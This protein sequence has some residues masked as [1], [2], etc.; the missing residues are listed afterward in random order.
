MK[1]ELKRFLLINKI[2]GYSYLV[3]LFIAMPLKYFAKIAIATKIVGMIHGILFIA[4]IYYLYI[5]HKRVPFTKRES[6]EY[7]V[8]SLIPFGSFINDRR[9]K[10]RHL[11]LTKKQINNK[12]KRDMRNSN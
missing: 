2:E 11:K 9:C 1:E 8:L 4:F 5:A 10:N 6:L 12:T 3:L 7:F